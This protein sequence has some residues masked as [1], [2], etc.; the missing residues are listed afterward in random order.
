MA[1]DPLPYN[2]AQAITKSDTDNIAIVGDGIPIA[3]LYIGAAGNFVAVFDNGD[4]ATFI[5]ALAGTI[6]PIG[7]IKRI[8]STNTTAATMLALYHI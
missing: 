3:A 8:N 5:G 4:T 2:Y 1:F 6:L 7:G